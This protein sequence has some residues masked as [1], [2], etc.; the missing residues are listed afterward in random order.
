MSGRWAWPDV[1]GARS[2][3]ELLA[4]GADLEPDTLVEAYALG[5]FPMPID[6]RLGWWSP[7][8]RGVL[9]LTGWH[10]SKSLRRSAARFEVTFDRAFDDV[11]AGCADPARD[12][13]WITPAIAVAYSQLAKLGRAHSVEVW[14]ADGELAGGLYGVALGGLFA[15]ESMFHVRTDASKVALRALV[16]RLAQAG[17]E[18]VLDV[19]WQTPHL[20][21]LGVVEIP[22]REYLAQ[23]A[24]ALGTPDAFA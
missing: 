18:R 13:G 9:P 6:D 15:G 10:E 12:H 7:D 3:V 1:A 24:H 16:A 14:D 21:S 23:L 20:A 5:L 22:R 17:G 4:L 11:V 8:P 2:G 19:Q